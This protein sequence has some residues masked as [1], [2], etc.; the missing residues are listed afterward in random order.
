MQSVYS[1]A[2]ID[3]AKEFR[4]KMHEKKFH[5]KIYGEWLFCKFTGNEFSIKYKAHDYTV[6]YTGNKFDI[7]CDGHDFTIKFIRNDGSVKYKGNELSIKMHLKSF[8]S[9]IYS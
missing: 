8:S 9:E 4:I 7:K 5:Y 1:A 6:K 2:S 3:L